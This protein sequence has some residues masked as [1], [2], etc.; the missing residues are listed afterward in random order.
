MFLNLLKK[1]ANNTYTENGALTYESTM[2]DC[3]DFFATVGALR[4]APEDE[5][6]AGFAR[7]YAEN[8]DM[9]LKILFYARDVRKGLGERRVFRVILAYLAQNQP[10]AVLKNIEN[11]GEYGRFDDLL[12]LMG[13]P[14]EGAA[15]RFF[16]SQLEK[17]MATAETGSGGVS[18]LA[19]W[20]PS[21]NTSNRAVAALGREIA[22]KMGFSYGDYRKML[23]K[24]RAQIRIIEN[25]LRLK[26]YTFD[27]EKQTSKSLFKYRKAFY[28]N[29][30]KRYCAFLEKAA[31]GSKVMHT[32]TLTPYDV[33][34]P[35][36]TR[37]MRGQGLTIPERH[38]VN[39]TWNA[40]ENYV[41]SENAIAVVDGSGS[42]YYRGYTPLP[43]AVAQSLGIYFAERNTGAFKGH[44][45]TFSNKPQLVQVKGKDIYEKMHYCMGFNEC[46]NTDLSA[47]FELILRTAV[48]NRVKQEAMPKRLYIISDMEF[49][50]CAENAS[51]S[52]FDHAKKQFAKFG[53][54]L[55][56]LV[57]WNVCSRN[58]QQPVTK[59]EKGVVLVSGCS[60]QIFSMLRNGCM[61]P[62]HFML[63][64]ISSERYSKIAA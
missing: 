41:G 8:A 4:N 3:L 38:S 51:V 37:A 7:A 36:V 34:A 39:V 53:Y 5:I 20:L 44:F 52:N 9:A 61:D 59:N 11:V 6:V 23:S 13:T 54:K 27:Y 50:A 45:I 18:L 32:G 63:E 58:R 60:P 62:Y 16:K 17:D 33:V 42:M 14:C 21:V 56:E 1:E 64:V 31:A 24:L 40:L 46:S 19:K 49:D 10:E 15:I 47:T 48:T 25:N 57:F 22:K 43:A 2:S 35:I 55:P 26:D 12:A 29:D 30:R 28:Q